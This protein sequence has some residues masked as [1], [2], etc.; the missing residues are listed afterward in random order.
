MFVF[1][2]AVVGAGTMGGEIAQAIAVSDID[3]VLK[4]IKQEFVDHGIQHARDVTQG[5]LGRL[6]KKE[7]LTQ[8]QADAR[9]EEVMGR[10]HGTLDYSGF[11]DVDFVIEAAPEKMEIKQ[12]VFRELDE[13]TPGHAILASNTSSLSITEMGDATLRPEKVV[14]FHF[15]YPASVM[16]L[17]EIVRGEDTSEAT[18]ATSINFAQAIKKQPITCEEVP[19]FVVN[20]ILNSAVGEIWRAQEEG[21]LSIKKIDESV[22][23][24]NVAP[25]GPFILVDLLGLDTVMHVAEHL[26][27]SYGDSFYVHEGMQ[28]LVADGKLGA[29]TGGSGFY[30]NG[31]PQIPGDGD[32][33]ED[34]ADLWTLKALVEACLV[35]EEGVCTVREIDLGMMAGAGLDPRR[36]LFPPFW[37][38]DIDGLDVTLEKLESAAEKHG[39]RFAPPRILKR[40]VAQGRLGLKAGQGFYAYPQA[41]EGEQTD[42]VKLETRGNVAIA[43]LANVPMN[44]VSP[45]V[46]EDLGTVWKKVNDAGNIGSMV[47]ASAIPVVFSAGADIKAFTQMDE[48]KGEGLI[49][50]GHALLRSFGT[51]RVTTIAAVNS[52]AFGGGCELAMACDFRIAADSAIFGQPEVKLGII[53]GFGG[54]QRLPRLVGPSKAL[55]MNLIGDA[56]TAG[57]AYEHGL[58]ARVVPDHELFDTA[59][60][61]ARGLAGQAPRAVELIKQVSHKGDLD[62]GIDAEKEGF[63]AAFATEDAKEGISAFLGKRTPNWSGK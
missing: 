5:Q 9:L 23:A 28:K 16:P 41:D 39:D 30:E 54:T 33:P 45:K 60:G 21:N 53:P 25:M 38:A 13:V 17:L 59:L 51:G 18:V 4:D 1:K 31:E 50:D 42:T 55:E 52:L 7:K 58:V 32:P 11:G 24:A 48:S 37:K 22:A 56:V 35:L 62:E 36:G 47:I 14:G 20:R 29:K 57:D 12:A 10:I 6:V 40:L 15:F 3:V 49:N 63:A 2:A 46:I 26:K 19:G 34:L 27:E 43:W 44:A 8:E 61:W